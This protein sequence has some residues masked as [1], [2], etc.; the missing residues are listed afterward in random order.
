MASWYGF[1][2]RISV[3][4]EIRTAD[5]TSLGEMSLYMVAVHANILPRSQGDSTGHD[6]DRSITTLGSVHL[7]LHPAQ[8]MKTAS[9]Y[10]E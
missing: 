1:I 8:M 5:V 9:T 10:G 4:P 3:Y 6:I 2:S 7:K